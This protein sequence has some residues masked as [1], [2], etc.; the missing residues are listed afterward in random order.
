MEQE[1]KK[2]ITLVTCREPR[3][4]IR[5]D[6][7]RIAYYYN[8]HHLFAAQVYEI[9]KRTSTPGRFKFPNYETCYWYAANFLCD[10]LTSAREERRPPH[11]MLFR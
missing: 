11:P 5:Q 10:H 3:V 6:S 9:E 2:D 1:R 7:R 4:H 8:S